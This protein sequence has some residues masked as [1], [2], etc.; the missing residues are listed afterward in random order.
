MLNPPLRQISHS[1]SGEGQPVH[2]GKVDQIG[3]GLWDPK[4][5]TDT[6]ITLQELD[7][8]TTCN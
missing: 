5:E 8:E 4:Q 1:Q 2:L 3:E 7:P 6:E